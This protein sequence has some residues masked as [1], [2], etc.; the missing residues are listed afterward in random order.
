MAGYGRCASWATA[1]SSEYLAGEGTN[2]DAAENIDVMRVPR[3]AVTRFIPV[4]TIFPPILAV[5]EEQT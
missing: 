1:F 2:S 5:L 3:N 4:D